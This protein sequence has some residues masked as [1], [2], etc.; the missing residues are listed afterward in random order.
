MAALFFSSSLR[1]FSSSDFFKKPS[2]SLSYAGFFPIGGY[3]Y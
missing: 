2:V 1:F 3:S